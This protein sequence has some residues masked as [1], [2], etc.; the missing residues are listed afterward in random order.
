MNSN[1]IEGPETAVLEDWTPPTS[2][3]LETIRLM[4]FQPLITWNKN[5]SYCTLKNIYPAF[6]SE[7]V[8]CLLTNSRHSRSGS[9]SNRD[10]PA[11]LLSRA[12][13][14]TYCLDIT[15]TLGK[16]CLSFSQLHLGQRKRIPQ[17]AARVHNSGEEPTITQGYRLVIRSMSCCHSCDPQRCFIQNLIVGKGSLGKGHTPLKLTSHCW[18]TADWVR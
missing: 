16:L 5:I 1:N 14:S 3:V 2:A 9:V 10:T 18:A 6:L 11:E 4:L 17:V 8:C 13:C 12:T 7:Y 15:W